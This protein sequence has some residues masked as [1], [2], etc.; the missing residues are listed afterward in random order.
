VVEAD[1]WLLLGAPPLD[2][3]VPFIEVVPGIDMISGVD[4]LIA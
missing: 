4:V 2:V 1:P 3:D